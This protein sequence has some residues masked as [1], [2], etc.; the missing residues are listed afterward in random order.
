[1]LP[2]Q[3]QTMACCTTTVWQGS[4]LGNI[5]RS[6]VYVRF[7]PTAGVDHRVDP[8]LANTTPVEQNPRVLCPGWPARSPTLHSSERDGLLYKCTQC[9][10]MKPVELLQKDAMGSLGC[11]E[12]CQTSRRRRS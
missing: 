5:M 10:Q 9:D 7:Y 1:M 8:K 11:I 4:R 2:M 12:E 6:S 3:A